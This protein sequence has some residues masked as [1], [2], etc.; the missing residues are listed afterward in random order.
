LRFFDFRSEVMLGSEFWNFIGGDPRT[1]EL[2]LAI[3]RE[4][5]A[6]YAVELDRLRAAVAGR[7]V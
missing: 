6:E 3:Y 5:G 2:L 7:A 4:V 1:Y